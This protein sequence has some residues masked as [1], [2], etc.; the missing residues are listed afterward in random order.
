MSSGDPVLDAFYFCVAV[1]SAL[2]LGS[3]ATALSYRLP[4][5]IS[6]VTKLRSSCPHCGHDLG[7]ADLVPVF[8]YLFLRGKCRHCSRAIGTH[9]LLIELSTVALAMLFYLQYGF[10]PAGVLFMALSAVLVSIIAI[11][12]AFKIIPDGLNATVLA[13]G[14]VLLAAYGLTASNPPE[15]IIKHGASALGG[16]LLYGG[17]SWL[18]RLLAGGW[19]GREAMGL[20]DVKFFAAAGFI[21]TADPMVFA[22][23]LMLS[24]FAGIGLALLWRRLHGGREFPFG[25]AIVVAFIAIL[26]WHPPG[27]F[28]I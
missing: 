5:G 26:L 21:L 24:G 22:W 7:L 3:F 18:L 25:P 12:L 13:I 15:F 1:F 17:G 19:L 14:V 11:D 16:V 20:G 2:C 28:P 4:R 9:Y 27:F 6:I 8:S 10:S 23:F